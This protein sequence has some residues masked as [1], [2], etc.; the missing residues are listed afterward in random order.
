MPKVF[1]HQEVEI[2]PDWCVFKTTISV[3]NQLSEFRKT[4]PCS[5]AIGIFFYH[6]PM[7]DCWYCLP[8]DDEKHISLAS[9]VTLIL[10][11]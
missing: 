9:V 1:C 3:R 7:P 5:Q 4:F 6:S 8:D 2:H 11:S 10:C